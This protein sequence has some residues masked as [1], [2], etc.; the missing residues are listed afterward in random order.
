MG[1]VP[2]RQ[3]T[4]HRRMHLKTHTCMVV[5]SL[6]SSRSGH[7]LRCNCFILMLKA[8][9][10][11]ELHLIRHVMSRS[12]WQNDIVDLN[13]PSP[14]MTLMWL[15]PKILIITFFEHLNDLI[16]KLIG[17]DWKKSEFFYGIWIA[18]RKA[19]QEL[20]TWAE[21]HYWPQQYFLISKHI[22]CF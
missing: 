3:G 4:D 9:M 7:I 14:K 19:F 12:H 17:I 18:P 11:F 16:W 20:S 6:I 22:M 8:F 15:E 10:A 5:S 13:N 21:W 1:P 2:N